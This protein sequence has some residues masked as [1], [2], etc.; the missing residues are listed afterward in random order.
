MENEPL[1]NVMNPSREDKIML[2]CIVNL[3]QLRGAFVLNAGALE[4]AKQLKQEGFTPSR[5]EVL[6]ALESMVEKVFVSME[7]EA[8]GSA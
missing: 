8:G 7:E 6:R 1:L 4:V 3:K 5:D 2:W